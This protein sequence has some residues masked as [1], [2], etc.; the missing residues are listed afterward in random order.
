M[1]KSC[2]LGGGRGSEGHVLKDTT[3]RGLCGRVLKSGCRFV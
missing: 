2:V 1:R 3:S